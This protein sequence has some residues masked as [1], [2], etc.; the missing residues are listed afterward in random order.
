MARTF[1]RKKPHLIRDAIGTLDEVRR[2][3]A[4]WCRRSDLTPEQAYSRRLARYT[5]DAGWSWAVPRWFTNLHVHRPERRFAQR[6]INRCIRSDC[7]DDHLVDNG[8]YQ[9]YYW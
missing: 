1:R 4:W 9:P 6:E 5:S 2:D 8:Y 3:G 7:W